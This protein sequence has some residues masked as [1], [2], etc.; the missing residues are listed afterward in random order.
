MEPLDRFRHIAKDQVKELTVSPELKQATLR[1]I[2]LEQ[3]KSRKPVR[4]IWPAI[5]SSAAALALV[6][7]LFLNSGAFNMDSGSRPGISQGIDDP[8]PPN[9]A[10]EPPDPGF[11][12]MNDPEAG[13]FSH[14][15][16]EA[17]PAPQAYVIEGEPVPLPAYVPAGFQLR[18]AVMNESGRRL[19]L[20]YIL[21]EKGDG[22]SLV[23]EKQDQAET[24]D[25]PVIVSTEPLTAEWDY[26]PWHYTLTGQ[27][28]ADEA[29]AI[30]GSVVLPTGSET[31]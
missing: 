4:W 28:A 2:R 24:M 19:E 5:S 7:V 16:N 29:N 12:V 14:H 10:G 27:L 18:N 13:L 8:N 20:Q 9:I 3:Q 1:R 26:G 21:L 31:K 30:A 6:L 15:G 25:S 11:T 23:I 22:F 17:D